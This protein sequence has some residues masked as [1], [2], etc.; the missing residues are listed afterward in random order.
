LR[1]CG[2]EGQ[3]ADTLR[4]TEPI[5]IEIEYQLSQP[6]KGLR[7]GLYLQTARGEVVFTSFDTDEATQFENL[8]IRPSGDFIS[9]CLIPADMLNEGRYILGINASSYRVRRYFQEDQA[10]TFTVDATDA[11]GMQ[12]PEVRQGLVRPRLA[13]Q[14]NQFNE[15]KFKQSANAPITQ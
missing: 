2:P 15:P 14:I 9:R 13:W 3:I 10:L 12:W 8:S 5:T 7:V 11:P 6:I 4:S 1:V